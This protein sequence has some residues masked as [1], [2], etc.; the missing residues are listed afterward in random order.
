LRTAQ[1]RRRALLLRAKKT[2]YANAH[3]RAR[4]LRIRRRSVCAERFS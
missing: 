2:F 4:R 1:A 3:D